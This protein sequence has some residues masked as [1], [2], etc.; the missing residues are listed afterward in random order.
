MKHI[1]LTPLLVGIVLMLFGLPSQRVQSAQAG[2]CAL[3]AQ[4]VMQVAQ[5]VCDGLK[6]DHICYGNVSIDAQPAAGVGD[7]Q[8]T[9]QGDVANIQDVGSLKLKSLDIN[10]SE[11]G[12]ALMKVKASL[13]DDSAENVTILLFGN[14]EVKNQGADIVNLPMTV[15]SAANV[16]LRP[17]ASGPVVGSLPVQADVVANGRM[18]NSANELWLRIQ[19]PAAPGGVGWVLAAVLTAGKGDVSSLSEVIGTTDHLYVPLQAFTFTSGK[20]DSPCEEAPESGITIQTPKG[21][22]Q[23]SLLINE[24]NVQIGSTAYFQ[25]IPG[26]E[27]RIRTLE[28]QLIVSS[29]G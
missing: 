15:R 24:V 9:Q 8:F 17:A 1:G 28:G 5:E 10:G 13:P 27:M 3:V 23:I 2:D 6:R 7:L 14:V 11:W 18:V 20:D 16:R 19:F 26:E 29:D 12:V 22:G 25:S 21:K 4:S